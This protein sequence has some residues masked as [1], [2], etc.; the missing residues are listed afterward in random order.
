MRWK[1]IIYHANSRH[2]SIADELVFWIYICNAAMLSKLFYTAESASLKAHVGASCLFIALLMDSDVINVT[3][4]WTY[5]P[6]CQIQINTW[7]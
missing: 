6:I 1:E 5:I 3:T 7:I 4:V 2:K